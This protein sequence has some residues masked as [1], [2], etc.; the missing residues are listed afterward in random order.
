MYSLTHLH[1]HEN[2]CIFCFG[3]LLRV[4]NF[5][6]QKN[7]PFKLVHFALAWRVKKGR[8]LKEYFQK[9][10]GK[11]NKKNTRHISFGLV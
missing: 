5:G 11:K 3:R 9:A 7:Y 10:Q 6:P 8:E 1:V 4:Q 2:E